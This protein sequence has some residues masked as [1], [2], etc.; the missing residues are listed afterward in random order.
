MIKRRLTENA[1]L[2]TENNEKFEFFSKDG[3]GIWLPDIFKI[4]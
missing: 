4:F 3:T 1:F 2:G